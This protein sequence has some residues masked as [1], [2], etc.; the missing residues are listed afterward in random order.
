MS[1]DSSVAP[2]TFAK[3]TERCPEQTQSTTLG[4]GVSVPK[5]PFGQVRFSTPIPALLCVSCLYQR[6]PAPL[7]IQGG[8]P[9]HERE[10]LAFEGWSNKI[11]G[12]LFHG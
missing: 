1:F 7:R 2:N 9:G 4:N 5:L 12:A 11:E 3:R 8:G 10:R 6:I